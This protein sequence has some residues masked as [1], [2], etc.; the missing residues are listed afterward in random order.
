VSDTATSTAEKV[1]WF[2]IPA[3]DTSKARDFYGRLFGWQFQPYEGQDYHM[4][5]DASGAIN[6]A[7]E[8]A[9]TIVFFGAD[10]I[11]AALA[12]VRELGGE[13]GEKQEI[14]GFSWA[15]YCKDLQGNN[16]G[17]SEGLAS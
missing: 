3:T 9:G 10:D 6:G 12:R 17:L 16:F 1:T 8:N 5:Y 13:A 15:A 2:E 11:D 4:T 7:A 14:P